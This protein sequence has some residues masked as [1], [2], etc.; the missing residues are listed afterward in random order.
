REDKTDPE[1]VVD[2]GR[3]LVAAGGGTHFLWGAVARAT[4]QNATVRSIRGLASVILAVRIGL[5]KAT[6]PLP[7]IACHVQCAI[8]SVACAR[9]PHRGCAAWPAVSR[10]GTCL[11]PLVSPRIDASIHATRRL[12]PLRLGRQ[13]PGLASQLG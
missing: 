3:H 2:V 6:Q 13:P 9:P 11:I 7:H 8:R 1:E 12:L 10:V 5:E 4:A